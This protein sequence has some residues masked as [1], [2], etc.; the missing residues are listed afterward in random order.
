MNQMVKDNKDNKDNKNNKDNKDNK[1]NSSN[2]L[3]FGHWPQTK[4]ISNVIVINCR[5]KSAGDEQ[6]RILPK[7]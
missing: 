7:P 4:T 3:V 5:A 6:S 1:N 2:S